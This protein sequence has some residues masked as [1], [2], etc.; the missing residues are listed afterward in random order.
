[1]DD[2]EILDIF[3]RLNSYG[4]KLNPQELINAK[5]FGS[6]KQFI[7]EL[8]YEYTTFWELNYI[9]TTAHML[10]MKEAEFVSELMAA[11]LGGIQD[12][13]AAEKYYANILPSYFH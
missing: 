4:V 5:Y 10:R 1:M 9:F 12:S 2:K 3:A 11:V 6:Y 8:G 13:K 7:Y